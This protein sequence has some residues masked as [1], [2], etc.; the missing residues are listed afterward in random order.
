MLLLVL[1]GCGLVA[2]LAWWLAGQSLAAAITATAVMLYALCLPATWLVGRL[3][4]S[5][6]LA[7]ELPAE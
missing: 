6:D 5:F 4:A 1:G 2:W 7:H 3:F